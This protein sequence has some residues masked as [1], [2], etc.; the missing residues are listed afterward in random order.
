MRRLITTLATVAL[1]AAAGLTGAAPASAATC[2]GSTCSS[3]NPDSTGCSTAGASTVATADLGYADWKLEMRY[4]STCKA[5]WA[6]VKN[7]HHVGYVGATIS[8]DRYNPYIGKIDYQ[9]KHVDHG[10]ALAYT[11]MWGQFTNF[12]YRVCLSF[13]QGMGT[14]CTAW[15]S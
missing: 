6:R 1:V 15:R 12:K 2:S 14:K 3:K 5:Y 13:D 10:Q 4:S 7:Y 9:S 11:N 8:V